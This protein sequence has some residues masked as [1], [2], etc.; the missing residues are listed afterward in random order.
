MSTLALWLLACA[1]PT[2]VPAPSPTAPPAAPTEVSG[3][4]AAPAAPAATTISPPFTLEQ[5][6]A[7]FPDGTRLRLLIAEGPPP[8]VEQRWTWSAADETG[9][10]ITTSLHSA[11]GGPPT[12]ALLA[13]MA[14]EAGPQ[15]HTWAELMGH[16]QFPAA[17]T[18]MVESTV[19]VPAGHFSTW[20]YTLTTTGHDGTPVVSRLH[21]AQATPG[22]PVSMTV[23]A[24][25]VE[26]YRM[27]L[28]ERTA[29]PAPTRPL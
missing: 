1:A 10:T 28:L 11:D 18:T 22:P 4:A 12:E 2:P 23:E 16:A 27:T 24:N 6:R 5:F 3:A 29:P 25:G 15:R 8:A 20:S 19:D 9:C 14:G 7:A 13:K 26:V 21:F 17:T